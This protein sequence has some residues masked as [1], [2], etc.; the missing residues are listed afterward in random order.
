V[1]GNFRS[2]DRQLIV[3][4]LHL[5]MLVVQSISGVVSVGSKGAAVLS[6]EE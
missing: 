2:T 4:V 3:H 1:V 5:L 6:L